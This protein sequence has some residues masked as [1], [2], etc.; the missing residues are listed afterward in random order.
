MRERIL[1]MGERSVTLATLIA[2]KHLTGMNQ[3]RSPHVTLRR[4]SARWTHHWPPV[5]QHTDQQTS[6]T[7]QKHQP[8][9]WHWDVASDK[10]F[11]RTTS[12]A[13][14]W[15]L[16]TST[17]S[18]LNLV[19]PTHNS[20]THEQTILILRMS[21]QQHTIQIL[22]ENHVNITNYSNTHGKPSK[23]NESQHD[24]LNTLPKRNPT[25]DAAIT[26]RLWAGT[27]EQNVRQTLRE[28]PALVN[29]KLDTDK[30]SQR[31]EPE[32]TSSRGS[33]K[34]GVGWT[35]HGR[36]DWDDPT[37]RKRRASETWTN[38]DLEK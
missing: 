12:I 14:T 21:H 38:R 27:D 32:M 28:A 23:Y 10:T 16:W 2:S 9:I 22:T 25:L 5:T 6:Q 8:K 3:R 29:F 19:D 1:T 13:R 34:K 15:V 33:P 11:A 35:H 17:A 24:Q 37:W 36:L 20:N 30:T 31:D 7:I 4:K 26:T 18:S